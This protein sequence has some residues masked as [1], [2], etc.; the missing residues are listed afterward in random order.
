MSADIQLDMD[1]LSPVLHLDLPFMYRLPA[2]HHPELSESSGP[3]SP[4]M[5]PVSSV[6]MGSVVSSLRP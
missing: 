2:Q 3:T 6:Y 4:N 1:A 5:A